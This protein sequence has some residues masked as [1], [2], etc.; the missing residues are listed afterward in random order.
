MIHILDQIEL[1]AAQVPAVLALLEANYLPGIGARGLSLLQR[2]V[3]PP[4]ALPDRATTLWLL[5]QVPDAA[6]YYGM[7]GTAGP[8]VI[9]FWRAV[10]AISHRRQRHVM[11]DAQQPLP[12][13]PEV[14]DAQ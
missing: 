8:E 12:A 7:R 6:A 3:S 1:E 9:E 11:A 5:W 2:W 4:V 14:S 13:L 10:D